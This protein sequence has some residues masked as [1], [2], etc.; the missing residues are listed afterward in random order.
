ML[1]TLVWK[2][3]N[4]PICL[5][6]LDSFILSLFSSKMPLAKTWLISLHKAKWSQSKSQG[7]FKFFFFFFRVNQRRES[8]QKA[9]SECKCLVP[10]RQKEQSKQ[11]NKKG[12]TSVKSLGFIILWRALKGSRTD[13]SSAKNLFI[14]LISGQN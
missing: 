14:L 9:P 7:S 1:K 2:I 8:Q 4:F 13:S 3:V 11:N 10:L 6:N 5:S 12:K